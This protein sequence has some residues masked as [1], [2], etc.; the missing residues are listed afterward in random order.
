[1]EWIANTKT[2]I[3]LKYIIIHNQLLY[4]NN[5]NHRFLW[6][7]SDARMAWVILPMLWPWYEKKYVANDVHVDIP[8]NDAY[9]SMIVMSIAAWKLHELQCHIDKVLIW[10][11][12]IVIWIDGLVQY[13][14]NSSA[15]VVFYKPNNPIKYMTYLV[16]ATM[17]LVRTVTN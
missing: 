10:R 12:Y 6:Y 4:R 9:K 15:S 2:S 3:S 17:W 13:C 11:L 14:S 5:R 16:Y 1:M 7:R 8:H